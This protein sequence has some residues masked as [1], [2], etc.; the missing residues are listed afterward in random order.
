MWACTAASI[1]KIIAEAEVELIEVLLR[2]DRQVRFLLSR[3]QQ[4]APQTLVVLSKR[5]SGKAR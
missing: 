3:I 5:N 4:V 2:T 1:T